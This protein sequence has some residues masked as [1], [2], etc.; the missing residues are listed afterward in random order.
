MEAGYP[1]GCFL[2]ESLEN[3]SLNGRRHGVSFFQKV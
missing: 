2:D 1:G 3:Y